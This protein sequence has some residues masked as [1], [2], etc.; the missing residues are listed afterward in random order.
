MKHQLTANDAPK[1]VI[2]LILLLALGTTAKV[3]S[4]RSGAELER[5]DAIVRLNRE[6]GAPNIDN[7]GPSNDQEQEKDDQ[8]EQAS[9][10]KSA[11]GV[12]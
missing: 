4:N 12:Q 11:S 7:S 2:G 5:K 8:Q 9:A 1:V 3:M 10:E 6:L